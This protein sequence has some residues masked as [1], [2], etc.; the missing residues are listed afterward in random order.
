MKMN[1]MELNLEE[2]ELANGGKRERKNHLKDLPKKTIDLLNS[3][4]KDGKTV[5]ETGLDGLKDMAK[6]IGSELAESVL[7]PMCE[8]IV[9][10]N[11]GTPW[12]EHLIPKRKEHYTMF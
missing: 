8:T 10:L 5:L 12:I 4:G 1:E 2:L 9:A 11:D 7:K 6:N 3:P